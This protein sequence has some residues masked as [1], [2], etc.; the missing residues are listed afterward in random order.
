MNSFK[1]TLYTVISLF[2]FTSCSTDNLSEEDFSSNLETSIDVENNII[3]A[4]E[5]MEALNE[6]RVS[7]GL[8]PLAWHDDSEEL[9]VEHSFYM[10]QNNQASHDNFYERSD[11]LQQGGANFVSENVAYGYQDA[12]SVLQGW[13]DSPSHKSAIEGDYTH[14]GIGIVHTDNGIPYYTQLFIR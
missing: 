11:A 3:L 10:V 1:I 4:E 12:A 9:A 14:S 8:N 7:I 13:L 2:V 6:Y 5:V